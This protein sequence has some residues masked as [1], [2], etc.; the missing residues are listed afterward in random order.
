M[1][2]AGIVIVAGLLLFSLIFGGEGTIDTAARLIPPSLSEPFGTDMLG[3]SLLE[4]T[5]GGVGISMAAAALVTLFSVLAALV[6]S[7]LC[8]LPRFPRQ[9]VLAAA[10]SLKAV[11]SIVLALFLSSL[12]GPGFMKMVIAI[13]L[14]HISDITRT[15]YSRT[16]SIM[17][18]EYITA[19]RTVGAGSIRIFIFHI[20]PGILRYIIM[21]AVSV[22]LSAVIAESTL[23]FLG[24]G[25]P[26]PLPSLGSILSEARLAMLS[27][28]W[29]I[30]IPASVLLLLGT[31]LSLIAFS[32]SESDPSSEGAHKRKLVGVSEIPSDGKA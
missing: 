26:A 17:S 4:R 20:L 24:C 21:Q 8:T 18:E 16:A 23:S 28:P 29:L 6:M 13:S 3:R 10:D 7:Y 27:A 30:A 19:S 15:A 14:S 5:A 22:F 25:I 9:A 32:F 12:S 11:P 1:R 31:G 2:K